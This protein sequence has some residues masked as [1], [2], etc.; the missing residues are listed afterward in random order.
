[1]Q[2]VHVVSLSALFYAFWALQSNRPF[3]R[4]ETN[5]IAH[6]KRHQRKG[7][8]KCLLKKTTR[9]YVKAHV[10]NDLMCC[11]RCCSTM[12]VCKL[13]THLYMLSEYSF[14]CSILGFEC[15]NY[16]IFY[17][18]CLHLQGIFRSSPKTRSPLFS[19]HTF[20]CHCFWLPF[21][22]SAFKK[23]SFCFFG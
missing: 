2:L 22:S 5:S 20:C 18:L 15:A 13:H 11:C 10:L 12:C 16:F 3:V 9:N 7:E 19:M 4:V 8:K 23:E 14:C 6:N 17:M 1:M 21:G